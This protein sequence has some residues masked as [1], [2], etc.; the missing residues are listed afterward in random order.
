MPSNESQIQDCTRKSI[1]HILGN[2]KK[3]LFSNKRNRTYWAFTLIE[4]LVVIAIISILASMLLPALNKA[5][6]KAR[7]ISC[8]GNFATLAKVAMM[9]SLDND[10]FIIPYSNPTI[11][12]FSKTGLLAPYLKFSGVS[13]L[14]CV[15]YYGSLN[16]TKRGL[17]TCPSFEPPAGYETYSSPG[18]ASIGINNY[19]LDCFDSNP[20]TSKKLKTPSRNAIFLDSYRSA[21]ISRANPVSDV[22]RKAE[23]RHNNSINVS[24]VD[25]HTEAKKVNFRGF[26]NS[27]SSNIDYMQFWAFR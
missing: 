4:L 16:A 26:L 18:A 17:L 24:F 13:D 25:G 10:D 3:L 1:G 11:T 9:Y 27:S 12:W 7:A 19:I 6:E 5:R 20:I 8:A 22:I 21:W 2:N 23:F 15:R 14:G